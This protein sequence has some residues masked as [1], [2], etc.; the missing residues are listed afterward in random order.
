[1]NEFRISISHIFSC[2]VANLSWCVTAM[3]RWLDFHMFVEY[4]KSAVV[5]KSFNKSCSFDKGLF[6]YNMVMP[7]LVKKRMIEADWMIV[8]M[9]WM[10][11]MAQKTIQHNNFDLNK[12]TT[13]DINIFLILNLIKKIIN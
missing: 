11:V 5:L 8:Q 10:I 6:N 1:M 3:D 7:Q 12:K 13:Y 9:I 2:R 4:I